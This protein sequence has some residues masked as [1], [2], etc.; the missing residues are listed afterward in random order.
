MKVVFIPKMGKDDYS[1]PKAYR[2]FYHR[3]QL[4]PL[5]DGELYTGSSGKGLLLFYC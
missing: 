3:F 1:V 5:N 4:S 2:P